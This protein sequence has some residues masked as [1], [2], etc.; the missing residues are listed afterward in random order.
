VEY[1]RKKLD[2]S[3][4][5]LSRQKE[6]FTER[7]GLVVL[8]FLTS[9]QSFA[10][11]DQWRE[12]PNY[13]E[14]LTKINTNQY[15]DVSFQAKDLL[16]QMESAT[17]AAD[18]EASDLFLR[19]LDSMLS[20]E[21]D[22]MFIM[23]ASLEMGRLHRKQGRYENAFISYSSALDYFKHHQSYNNWG[24]ALVRLAEYYRDLDRFDLAQSHLELVIELEKNHGPL[25]PQSLAIL[26]H[27][28]AAISVQMKLPIEEAVSYSERS[29]SYSEPNN[30]KEDMATS[31]L[32]LGYIYYNLKD[33]R[34]EA[35]YQE[36]LSIWRRLGLVHYEVNTLF[37]LA[38]LHHSTGNIARCEE[39]LEEV[40]ELSNALQLRTPQYD[41][42]FLKSEISIANGRYKEALEM[43][44]QAN[45]ILVDRMLNQHD[46]AIAQISKKYESDLTKHQLEMAKSEV[47]AAEKDANLQRKRQG[48]FAALLIVVLALAVLLF[49]YYKRLQTQSNEVDI[50]RKKIVQQNAKLTLSLS[51]K[52]TLLQEVHHRVQNNL[53]FILALIEMQSNSET[54]E[55]GKELLG[56]F[57]QRVMAIAL[58]HEQL[59]IEDKSESVLISSYV[60]QLINTLQQLIG[61]KANPIQFNLELEPINLD[62]TRAVAIGMVLNELVTNSMKYAFQSEQNPQISILLKEDLDRNEI[63][64]EYA[65][66]GSG[67][68]G[69][70]TAGLGSRLINMFSRRL[71]G[72]HEILS[73]DGVKYR[74]TFTK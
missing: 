42:L 26:W 40:L 53:Q 2:L 17:K 70:V 30:F 16:C 12:Q 36:A 11:L 37:N 71:R 62:V 4:V 69:D 44:G 55:S 66:N 25:H 20:R 73:N 21:P 48:F 14:C 65:D 28:Y 59:H 60:R 32:E 45:Q 6:L 61:P 49:V 67:Y 68:V 24:L 23:R 52:E 50:Q 3:T 57:S 72:K 63:S 31:Y 34:A 46:V 51:E 64:L 18:Y 38:R 47:L 35:Y 22:S 39:L 13:V 7:W 33:D 74:I 1:P 29:L 10:Q 15:P 19:Q 58:V 27:R 8:I 56:E 54:E 43:R 41:A 9:A 5:K